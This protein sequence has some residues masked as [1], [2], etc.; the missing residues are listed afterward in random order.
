VN[1]KF[2]VIYSTFF[3]IHVFNVFNAFFNFNLNVCFYLLY[4]RTIRKQ[5]TFHTYGWNYEVGD[6]VGRRL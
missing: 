1:M 3:F 4:A 5:N 2:D 6:G